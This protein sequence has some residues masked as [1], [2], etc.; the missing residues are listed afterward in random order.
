MKKTASSLDCLFHS[1]SLCFLA[2]G[3]LIALCSSYDAQIFFTVIWRTVHV[4]SFLHKK[5]RMSDYSHQLYLIKQT[6]ISFSSHCVRIKAVTRSFLLADNIKAICFVWWN[7]RSTGEGEQKLEKCS[8]NCD[9]NEWHE[10]QTEGGRVHG[11][12]WEK[13]K[14]RG[15]REMRRREETVSWWRNKHRRNKLWKP[16]ERR[17]QT[18]EEQKG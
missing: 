5:G 2:S 10:R 6:H 9:V 16:R 13:R 8:H 3:H 4:F 17:R 15:E 1:D 7:V 12:I 11:S 14:I 18:E